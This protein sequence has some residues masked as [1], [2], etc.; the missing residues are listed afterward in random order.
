MP[1]GPCRTVWPAA[2]RRARAYATSLF[3]SRETGPASAR[4]PSLEK[5]LAHRWTS[6]DRS[7]GLASP[8][9]LTRFE[10]LLLLQDDLN[11]AVLRL[12]DAVGGRNQQVG[13]AEALDRD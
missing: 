5:G 6:P 11:A 1:C 9:R 7:A 8:S 13:F 2:W 12:A 4:A 3:L 10:V